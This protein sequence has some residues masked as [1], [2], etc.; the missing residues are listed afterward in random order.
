ME[1]NKHRVDVG[2]LTA[3]GRRNSLSLRLHSM[4]RKYEFLL[5]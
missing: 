4:F 5:F 1:V 2:D 3:A